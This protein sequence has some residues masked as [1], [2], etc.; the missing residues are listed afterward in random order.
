M[1]DIP[2]MCYAPVPS[3][4][5][6]QPTCNTIET[7]TSDQGADSSSMIPEKLQNVTCAV[8]PEKV[9]PN[10]ELLQGIDFTPQKIIELQREDETLISVILYLEDGTLPKLQKNVRK[11]LL[12]APDYCLSNGLLFHSRK[13]KSKRTQKMNSYQLVLPQV[14][15]PQIL[16]LYHESPLAGHI[17]IQQTI[18]NL[19]E[20]RYFSRLPS[21]VSD[22]VR[23]CHEY[24]ER[25]MT[26]AHTKFGRVAYK[27]PSHLFQVWQMDAYGPLPVTQNRNSYVFTARD[28]FSKYLFTMAMPNM[29]SI[30]V[31]Q[32]LFQL[33]CHIGIG[34]C[35][36]HDNG[37]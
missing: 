37:N 6:E 27:P 28:M 1:M 19:S 20:Q 4:E 17:G 13:A 30:T 34:D 11:L 21:I 18:D 29:D 7:A 36:I 5:V 12:L 35:I 16:K 33:T 26:K 25:K 9:L 31:S 3:I 10:I 24:Q 32:V 15:I 23:S 22:F 8:D 2:V 14:L